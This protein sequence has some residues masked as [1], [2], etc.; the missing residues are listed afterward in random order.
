MCV[1]KCLNMNRRYAFRRAG[2]E[3]RYYT[4]GVAKYKKAQ[5]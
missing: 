2:R 5:L 1:N 4:L 3:A